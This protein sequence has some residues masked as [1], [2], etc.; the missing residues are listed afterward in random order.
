MSVVRAGDYKLILKYAGPVYELY[1]LKNDPFESK[2]LSKTEP[3]KLEEMKKLLHAWLKDT[4]AP[5]ADQPNPAYDPAS[6]EQKGGGHGGKK[7]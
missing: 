1:N 6:K 3:A 5:L 4:Q 7:R 2:E